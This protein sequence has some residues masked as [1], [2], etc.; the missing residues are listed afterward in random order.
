MGDEEMRPEDKRQSV[1]LEARENEVDYVS[2]K[3][4]LNEDGM[5]NDD[6]VAAMS[7]AEPTPGMELME[8]ESMVFVEEEEPEN[9][10]FWYLL[11]GAGVGLTTSWL[12]GGKKTKETIRYVHWPAPQK[13]S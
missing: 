8:M 5:W 7:D 11:G 13:A 10:N 1:V 2:E 3:K 12:L 4:N 9:N 6:D